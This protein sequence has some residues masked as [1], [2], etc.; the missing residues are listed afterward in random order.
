MV[1]YSVTVNVDD[2]IVHDW[3]RWMKHIHIPDVMAT[4]CFTAYGFHQLMDPVPEEGTQTYNIQYACP[5]YEVLANYRETFAPDLQAEVSKRY[6][7][8]FFAFR[9]VLQEVNA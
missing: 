2:S 5:N 7:G 3:V 6:E 9:T 4:G 8:K 1:I